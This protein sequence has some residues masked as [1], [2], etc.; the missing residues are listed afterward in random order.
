MPNR[1][2]SRLAKIKK[3]TKVGGKKRYYIHNRRRSLLTKNEKVNMMKSLLY[4]LVQ[5]EIIQKSFQVQLRNFLMTELCHNLL[6]RNFH[7]SNTSELTCHISRSSFP[8]VNFLITIFIE[9]LS[10]ICSFQF[11]NRYSGK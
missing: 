10:C 7:K 8:H 1:A 3:D 4:T 9:V 5:R 6:K 2:S 11:Q